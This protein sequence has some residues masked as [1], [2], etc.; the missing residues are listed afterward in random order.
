[1]KTVRVD[2]LPAEPLDAASVFDQHWRHHVEHALKAG[3][4]VAVLLAPADHT[5]RAWRRAM[6]A[7]LARRH[8]PARINIVAGEGAHAAATLDYLARAPGVTG[9]YLETAVPSGENSAEG[10]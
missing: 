1:M 10:E 4:D 6:A 9:Q 8:T 3:E 5:H 7:G 2:D